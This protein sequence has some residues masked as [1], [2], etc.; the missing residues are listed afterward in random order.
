MIELKALD[1]GME[2]SLHSIE[3][4]TLTTVEF[5]NRTSGHMQ[6]FWID[7]T[8]QRVLYN[9]LW[10]GESHE[11][12]TYLT[13]PWLI[14]DSMGEC[15]CIFLPAEQPSQAVVRDPAPSGWA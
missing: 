12:K 4:V 3:A 6:V 1:C 11:Q 8:G 9:I 13:H 14:V 5:I 2:G 7:Y 15:R 10:P